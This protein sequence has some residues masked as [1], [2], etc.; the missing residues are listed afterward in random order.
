MRKLLFLCLAC[1]TTFGDPTMDLY[2]IPDGAQTRWYSFEIPSQ[3]ARPWCSRTSKAAA[4]SGECG[5]R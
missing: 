1:S 3:R 4:Q 2:K 5:S